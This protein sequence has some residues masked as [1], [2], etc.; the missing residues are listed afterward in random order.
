VKR[1]LYVLW[2]VAYPPE[3]CYLSKVVL[4]SVHVDVYSLRWEIYMAA[5]SAYKPES[6]LEQSL[7]SLSLYS[8]D[9]VVCLQL[10][11]NL[12]ALFALGLRSFERGSNLGKVAYTCIVIELRDISSRRVFYL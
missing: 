12:S 9:P 4:G 8:G 11:T 6:H 10:S 1:L 5:V 3:H 2:G 7:Y